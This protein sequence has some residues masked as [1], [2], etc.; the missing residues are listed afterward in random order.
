MKIQTL[1]QEDGQH[2]KQCW[3]GCP[4]MKVFAITA[5]DIPVTLFAAIGSARHRRRVADVVQTNP[6]RRGK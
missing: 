6:I 4:L 3:G 1:I 5:S 2:F